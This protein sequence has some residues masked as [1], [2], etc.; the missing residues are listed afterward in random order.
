MLFRSDEDGYVGEY[1]PYEEYEDDGIGADYGEGAA[2]YE[3]ISAGYGDGYGDEASA[4][5]E[6]VPAGYED[7]YEEETSADAEA[8]IEETE[9]EYEEEV[10]EI[11]FVETEQ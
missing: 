2:G 3:D 6:E 1:E 10:P 8:D 5:Y 7:S 9:R 4:G 11:E